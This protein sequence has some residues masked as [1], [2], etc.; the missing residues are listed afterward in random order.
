MN[1]ARRT[2]VTGMG[3]VTPV[4]VGVRN[5][6]QA[7]LDARSG[8]RRISRFDPE[9]HSVMIGGEVQDFDPA[10]FLPRPFDHRLETYG[11][12]GVVAALEAL[13]Q[14]GVDPAELDL[15]R[16]SVVVGTGY[17]CTATNTEAV[18]RLDSLGPT[19]MGPTYSVFGAQDVVAGYLS[20]RL[21][22]T[23]EA[24]SVS[25]ACAS[26]TVA[27][28]AGLRLLR[29]GVADLVVV[30]GAEGAVEPKDLAVVAGARALTATHNDDP[31]TASRPFDRG[32]D[33]F[34]MSGGGAALVLET[35]EHATTRGAAPLAEVAGY[36]AA[37]DAHHLT[38]PHPEGRGALAAMRK[39]V[40]EAGIAPR[41]IDHVNAHGTSTRLNDAIEAHAL[42]ELLGEQAGRA[43]ITSTKSMTGHMIGAAGTFEAIACVQA[44][45]TGWVPETANC[46]D[47]EF[48]FLD[49]VRGGA[50]EA[51]P[52]I[53]LSN[54]FGFGGHCASVVLRAAS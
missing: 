10:A 49:I 21:G 27:I 32:R 14:A 25:T 15:E 16:V 40:A 48:D 4:G 44:L 45:R 50:R 54:S 20:M 43:A 18:R 41:D 46:D 1:T 38:A 26:G 22:A 52:R 3:A 30:V 7:L 2:V 24:L 28:G 36:G 53:A 8:V 17:G 11:Q 42:S 51:R 29:A 39:A 31:S 47:L 34:V 33:G 37:S 23:G 9:G 5:A 13:D 6:W 12:Y 35:A 19:R